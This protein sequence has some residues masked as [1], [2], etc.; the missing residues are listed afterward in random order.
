M[1]LHNGS[2]F[3]FFNSRAFTPHLSQWYNRLREGSVGDKLN[4]VFVSSDREEEAYKKY[5]KQMPWHA[6]PYRERQRKV[7]GRAVDRV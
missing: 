4:I 7:G 6:L 2:L 1:P 5:F 3:V